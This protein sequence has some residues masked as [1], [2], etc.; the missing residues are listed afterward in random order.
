MTLDYPGATDTILEDVNN[1]GDAVGFC[2]GC[3][4]KNGFLYGGGTFSKIAF[5]GAVATEAV[6]INDEGDIVG[7]YQDSVG[8]LHGF[9]ATPATTTIRVAID[10]RPTSCPNPINVGAPGDLPLAILGTASFD[11]TKVDP[12]SVKLQGVPALRSALEDV[13]TPYAGPL[14]NATSCTTAGPD[15]FTDLVLHFDNKAVSAALGTPAEGQVLILTLTGNL[16]PQFGGTAIKGQDVVI[17][18]DNE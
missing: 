6:G 4:G 1:F 17:I 16:L 11:V 14:M 3:G 10:I 2:K 9:L 13:A 5:P 7:L 18:V 8:N 12:S 15:G